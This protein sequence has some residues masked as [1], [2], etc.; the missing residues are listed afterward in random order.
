LKSKQYLKSSI[1]KD[2]NEESVNF[3][4]MATWETDWDF[5]AKI[6]FESN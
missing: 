2:F 3:T 5:Q 1:N 4:K 6:S